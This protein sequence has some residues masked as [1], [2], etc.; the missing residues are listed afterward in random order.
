MAIEKGQGLLDPL[1]TLLNP[2]PAHLHQRLELRARERLIA[3]R[4]A[5]AGGQS[6]ER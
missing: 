1:G 4:P 2:L 5:P 6:E 3:Q